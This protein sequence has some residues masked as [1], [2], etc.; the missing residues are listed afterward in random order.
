MDNKEYYLKV[1]KSP[2]MRI[3]KKERDYI[4]KAISDGV[5]YIILDDNTIMVNSIVGMPRI[6]AKPTYP[7]DFDMR[8]ELPEPDLT[9]EERERR[10]NNL[11]KIKGD[12]KRVVD[13]V[14]I[15]S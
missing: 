7:V 13:S 11:K 2:D 15:D 1:V 4:L 12:F 6:T 14:T 8:F 10:L 5:K 3:T 9:D